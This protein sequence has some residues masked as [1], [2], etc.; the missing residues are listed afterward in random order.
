MAP[1]N[2]QE[3][4]NLRGELQRLRAQMPQAFRGGEG[5]GR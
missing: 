3:N 5:I 1:C 2:S 4:V